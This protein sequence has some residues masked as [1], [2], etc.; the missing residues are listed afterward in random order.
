MELL[1]TRKGIER[2]KVLLKIVNYY[3]DQE[4]GKALSYANEILR[5]TPKGDTTIRFKAY[6]KAFYLSSYMKDFN[7]YTRLEKQFKKEYRLH[8][9]KMIY[10]LNQAQEMVHLFQV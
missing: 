3:N 4:P 7:L 10:V 2:N 5:N 6:V 1:K 8:P 9:K